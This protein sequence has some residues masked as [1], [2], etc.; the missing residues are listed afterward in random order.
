MPH[1]AL[2]FDIRKGY[3]NVV[4]EG[5]NLTKDDY[6]Q[7]PVIKWAVKNIGPLLTS[8]PG[9]ILYGEGWEIYAD[10]EPYFEKVDRLP[11][12]MLQCTCELDSRLITDFWMRFQ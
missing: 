2:E 4:L 6:M 1:I 12:V 8:E 5:K 9:Q 11:R 7:L 10:W 3:S